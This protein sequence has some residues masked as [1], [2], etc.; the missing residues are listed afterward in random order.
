MPM[1][2]PSFFRTAKKVVAGTQPGKTVISERF[3]STSA[4]HPA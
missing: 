4:S 3:P 1:I 2:R